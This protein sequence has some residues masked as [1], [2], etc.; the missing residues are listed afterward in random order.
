MKLEKGKAE[1]MYRQM[2]TIR[3]FEETVANLTD[4]GKIVGEA[5]MYIGQEASGVGICAALN[6]DDYI[7][8]THR[9]H[10]HVIAK[11]ADIRRMMAELYGRRTGYCK[12]KG[13]SMHVADVSLGILGAN[14]IVGGGISIAAG[15]ALASQ[16]KGDGRIAVSFFGDGA[17]N[18]GTFHESL[19][20]ASVW[21]LPIIFVCENN[22]YQEF[23]PSAP[24]IAG[25]VHERAQSYKIPGVLVDGQDVIAVYEAAMQAVQRARSGQG[26]TLIETDTYRYGGHFIGEE[27]M[28]ASYRSD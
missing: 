6:D 9:G 16:V 22:K 12:G 5:H 20:L 18:E 23:S 13:G 21:K 8:S 17:S 11:G 1:K 24:L 15:A 28:V 26:P 3:R 14:G 7:T 27:K 10:G 25:S 4:L 2:F 19:N